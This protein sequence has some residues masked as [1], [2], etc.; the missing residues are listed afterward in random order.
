MHT[1]S[2]YGSTLKQGILEH[3]KLISPVNVLF[4]YFIFGL[5]QILI[6]QLDLENK[7][8]WRILMSAGHNE[9]ICLECNK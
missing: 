5:W 9:Q 3:M 4:I 7:L 1:T 8:F 2:V 6:I